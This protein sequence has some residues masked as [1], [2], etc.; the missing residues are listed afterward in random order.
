MALV[1]WTSID[2]RLAALQRQ[3][4]NLENELSG[5]QTNY[6]SLRREHEQKCAEAL[7]QALSS[8]VKVI[9][10]V[11]RTDRALIFWVEKESG[12][13]TALRCIG[14]DR[15]TEVIILKKTTIIKARVSEVEASFD[16]SNQAFKS[17][18]SAVQGL[19]MKLTQYS[20]TSIGHA[21]R[22]ITSFSRELDQKINQVNRT[23]T[24]LKAESQDVEAEAS[25]VPS[26]ISAVYSQRQE[27]QEASN[28][29]GR[30]S[31]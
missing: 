4:T 29:A 25:E 12:L 27:A 10:Y 15:R 16:R 17:G 26:R 11:N 28:A 18:L 13:K 20:L 24:K 7:M 1:S 5:I 30:V 14:I 8:L 21:Q 23:I 22:E 6:D 2:S 31:V 9:K 3:C 19:D